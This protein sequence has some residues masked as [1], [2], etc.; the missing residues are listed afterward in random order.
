MADWWAVGVAMYAAI[1]ATGALALEIRRWFDG[2]ARLVV[3]A[4]PNIKTINVRFGEGKT[5]VRV[6]VINRGSSPTTITGLYLRSYKTVFHKWLRIVHKNAVVANPNLPGTETG[7]LPSMLSPGEQWTGITLQTKELEEWTNK[8][9]VYLS[10][11]ST[12]KEKPTLFRLNA[13]KT[14][15]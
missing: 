15:R 2:R 6:Y 1:V 12:H 5:F 3:D 7:K 11:S 8:D 13:I 9:I 4:A 14:N 10:V